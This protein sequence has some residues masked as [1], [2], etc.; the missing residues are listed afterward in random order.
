MTRG[1]AA[2]SGHNRVSAVETATNKLGSGDAAKVPDW[3]LVLAR[4]C[5]ASNRRSVAEIVGCRR[6]LLS[7]VFNGTADQD[8]NDLAKAVRE[9]FGGLFPRK[10]TAFET[11]TQT[12]GDGNFLRV[13]PYV[14]E[15]AVHC[16]TYGVPYVTKDLGLLEFSIP[17]L[18][19]NTRRAVFEAVARA[20]ELPS[21][22]A[23]GIDG[24]TLM[25]SRLYWG[26]EAWF[27]VPAEIEKLA[28]MCDAV[29]LMRDVAEQLGVDERHVWEEITN[30]YSFVLGQHAMTRFPVREPT[31]HPTYDA[32]IEKFGAGEAIPLW[33]SKLAI[34]CDRGGRRMV[35]MQ[36][37]CGESVLSQL[38]NGNYRA[39]TA[40]FEGFVRGWLM[41]EHVQCPA[42]GAPLKA[43]ACVFNQ[44][45]YARFKNVD[46]PL[47]EHAFAE[48]CRRC[49]QNK[50]PRK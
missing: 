50:G 27:P 43:D 49:P 28:R 10:L 47:R 48:T 2:N 4:Q 34:A 12:W 1:F 22:A 19:A 32:L 26:D 31:T 7:H 29:P 5:D 30:H 20:P 38:L 39:S 23:S 33:R 35:A 25:M 9:K 14:F 17:D 41:G 42:H 24:R 18:L 13:P 21:E 16:D 8:L 36:L 15:L 44:R 3:I 37:G 40:Q 46:L 6:E 45:K 11:V